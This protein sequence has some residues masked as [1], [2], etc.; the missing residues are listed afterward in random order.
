MAQLIETQEAEQKKYVDDKIQ[1]LSLD[2]GA[3]AWRERGCRAQDPADDG[4][5][6][7]GANECSSG[8]V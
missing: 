2:I 5:Q 7:S 4:G 1:R 3:G 8:H 6:P